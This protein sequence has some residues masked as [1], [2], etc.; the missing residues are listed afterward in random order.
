MKKFIVAALMCLTL[1]AGA[2][3][4]DLSIYDTTISQ[5][6]GALI[7]IEGPTTAE[8]GD[9]VVLSVEKSNGVSFK[10]LVSP[11]TKNVL[12]IDGGK[13]IVFSSGV[14][15]TFTFHVATAKADTV[16][17]VVHTVVI[18]A[19]GP[20]PTPTPTP[21]QPEPTPESTMTKVLKALVAGVD[22]D[23]KKSEVLEM[24]RNFET[25]SMAI[26]NGTLETPAE[27]VAATA[28]LNKKSLGDNLVIW[29]SFRE[30]LS[31]QLKTMA[32]DGV[33]SDTASHKTVWDEIAASLR[34]V[35]HTL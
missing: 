13:R 4:Q 10:W 19:N 11:A 29:S 14:E 15:G 21:P 12:V 16:D 9:L 27:V 33:L 18:K 17:M 25:V 20:E 3:A 31:D 2:Y 32:S 23:I 6:E 28:E 7:I 22:S 5:D 35:A 8:I 34:E 30:G 1:T 24:A 26:A